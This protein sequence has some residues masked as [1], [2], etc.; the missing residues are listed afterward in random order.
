MRSVA[1]PESREDVFFKDDYAAITEGLTEI[2]P[3]D[4]YISKI[5]LF[6][7]KAFPISVSG[8]GYVQVAAA[9]YGTVCPIVYCS[10]SIQHNII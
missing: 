6:G 5:F 8:D 9:R 4:A 7:E 2:D 10:I 1:E 3:T